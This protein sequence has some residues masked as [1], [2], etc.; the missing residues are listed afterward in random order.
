MALRNSLIF[1]LERARDLGRHYTGTSVEIFPVRTQV[2]RR[3]RLIT[4]IHSVHHAIAIAGRQS[5]GQRQADASKCQR[6]QIKSP[7]RRAA[8]PVLRCAAEAA[9]SASTDSRTRRGAPLKATSPP[10]MYVASS[11]PGSSSRRWVTHSAVVHA[12]VVPPSPRALASLVLAAPS[13]P[14]ALLGPTSARTADRRLACVAS[15]G[16]GT[17]V[18]PSSH[19]ITGKDEKG[20]GPEEWRARKG[21]EQ[22]PH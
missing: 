16:L 21:Q 15:R 7:Y 18:G 6:E 11:A 3:G 13:R 8:L 1:F 4:C 17:V 2:C 10:S 19:L 5:G 22:A 20:W 12:L 14:A 9:M